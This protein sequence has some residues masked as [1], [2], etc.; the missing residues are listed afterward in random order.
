MVSTGGFYTWI[1]R[2]QGI[3]QFFIVSSVPILGDRL[4]HWLKLI[5]D[6]LWAYLSQVI[7]RWPYYQDFEF[8]LHLSV[9]KTS[10]FGLHL[11]VKKTSESNPYQLTF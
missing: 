11:S 1:E 3:F 2:S 10:E 7:K 4:N 9:K 5:L 6:N 8:D